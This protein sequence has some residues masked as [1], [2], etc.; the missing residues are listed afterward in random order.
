MKSLR[1]SAKRGGIPAPLPGVRALGQRA[2]LTPPFTVWQLMGAMETKPP[3]LVEEAKFRGQIITPT[4]TA[5]G[6]FVDLT[7]RSNGTYKAHFHLHDSG[8]PDYKF[9]VRALFSATNGLGF[10]MQRS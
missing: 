8:F 7:L 6:G 2:G 9:T 10:A 4:G 1:E 5:L 3:M